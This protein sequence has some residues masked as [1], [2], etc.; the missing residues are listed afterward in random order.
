METG[1]LGQDGPPNKFAQVNRYKRMGTRIQSLLHPDGS[2]ATTYQEIAL[3]K[4]FQDFYR[5]DKEI[6]PTFQS[7]TEMRMTNPLATR[8]RSP[9]PHK[10]TDPGGLFPNAFKTLSPD[11][12]PF[13]F[14]IL[15]LSF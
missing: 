1:K 9:Q 8:L 2:H 6:T 12:A 4:T 7:I 10:G 13:L 15:N 11:I 3:K 14:Q 5:V